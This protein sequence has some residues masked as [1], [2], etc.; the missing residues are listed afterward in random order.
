MNNGAF[1]ENFPYSNFHDLNLDWIIKIAKDF[2]DQYTHI[3]ETIDNG[4]NALDEKA[5]NLQALLQEWYDTH[6]EDIANQL[7]DALNDLNDWYTEHQGYLD[8]YLQDSIDA[9]GAAADAKAADTIAS[10]PG[11][12]SAMWS[13]YMDDAISAS[14]LFSVVINASINTI[15]QKLLADANGRALYFPC[16]PNTV[17]TITKEAGKRFGIGTTDVKPAENISYLNYVEDY[18]ETV[19][20]IKTP[21]NAKYLFVWY[22]HSLY[23]T[24]SEA[25]MR[26]SIRIKEQANL[27][28]TTHITEGAW[29][30]LISG[31]TASELTLNENNDVT[32]KNTTPSTAG[33]AGLANYI[34]KYAN[35]KNIHYCVEVHGD[36]TT[37]LSLKMYLSKQHSWGP[38]ASP[39]IIEAFTIPANGTKFLFF[40]PSNLLSN[41]NYSD[42]D[43]VYFLIE[44]STKSGNAVS[45]RV[46]LYINMLDNTH[47]ATNSE[48]T[49]F[50]GVEKFRNASFY[51]SSSMVSIGATVSGGNG[52]YK[53]TIPANSGESGQTY[54]TI[55]IPIKSFITDGKIL[56]YTLKKK[57]SASIWKWDSVRLSTVPDNWAPS[58]LVK[59]LSSTPGYS[60]VRNYEIDLGKL[61]IDTSQYSDEIYLIFATI[62]N[63]PTESEADE[64][65]VR[66]S[67]LNEKTVV[68][69]D[70]LGFIQEDYYDKTEINEILG[71]I[72]PTDE[73]VFWGDSLTAGAGG[74]GVTYCS[75]CA[76]LLGKSHKNCGVGG[77][78]EQTVAA[79]QGGNNLII[80][81]GNVN[82]NY[83]FSQMLDETGKQILPL[84]Q[85]TGGN[86]VN[87]VIINGQECALSLSEETYTISGYNGTLDFATPALFNGYKIQG[88]ITVI[89]VGANG[90]G[91]NTVAERISYIKSMISRIGRKYVVMGISYGNNT[92]RASDDAAMREA[93]GNHFFP[94]R[95]MLVN[96]GLTVAGI[97][98]TAQD[99]ADMNDGVVPT[100]L[101]SDHI[102]LNADG[103]TALGKMLAGF[104]VGLGY[105]TY[106]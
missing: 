55:G 34:G 77:E 28:P 86:T 85:G 51:R 40:T 7:A 61:G 98:P 65:T 74:G 10:I 22:W 89:F 18:T 80:P 101:R 104:I 95:K 60:S 83:T 90:L 62:I 37:P 78:T 94:T 103:Y 36:S 102:H 56:R 44:Q 42:S 5:T 57:N 97:T 38:G 76:N 26:Q 45:L 14:K 71:G 19:L 105:A 106:A 15:Q 50:A 30:Q 12:Y 24:V 59:I 52:V 16:Q 27:M 1:G 48:Y 96:N 70:L 3:Q 73:I 79:R 23:D 53:I 69:T 91:S 11:D 87:P 49:D 9:F 31:V 13:N 43:D 39:A 93:F 32:W 20:T 72:A 29:E 54:T 6:S 88:D 67:I 2:L 66:Y 92:D 47:F 64:L 8:Q 25:E 17:Y 68:A 63:N 41:L 21:Y 75:V 46:S 35:V 82:G 100:S 33:Y 4:L 58:V 81:P 84:R 99:I